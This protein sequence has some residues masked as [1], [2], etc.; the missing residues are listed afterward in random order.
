MILASRADNASATVPAREIGRCERATDRGAFLP[1]LHGHF[2]HDFLDE[3]IE[4]RRALRGRRR[5]HRG[6][7]AISLYIHHCSA[8]QDISVTADLARGVG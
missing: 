2:A 7:H 8:R 5:E 3:S 6:I 4:C 1:R